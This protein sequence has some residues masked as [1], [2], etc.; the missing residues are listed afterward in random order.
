[1]TGA[2]AHRP[3]LLEECIEAFTPL[4][5]GEYDDVHIAALLT[6]IKTRG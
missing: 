2:Y 1:M 6:T 4:T 5:V 3:V